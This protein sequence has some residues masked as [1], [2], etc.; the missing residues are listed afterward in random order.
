MGFAAMVDGG[1]GGSKTVNSDANG[2]PQAPNLADFALR[3]ER[4]R[5]SASGIFFRRLKRRLAPFTNT[6][7]ISRRMSRLEGK[8]LVAQGGGPTA[9]IN[10]SIVGVTLE[11]RKSHR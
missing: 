9:V 7:Q 3:P 5:T 11:A 2:S 8:V 10:Q 1:G 4:S 6:L